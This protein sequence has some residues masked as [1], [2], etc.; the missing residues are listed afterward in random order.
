MKLEF[1]ESGS[2][3]CPLVRLYGFDATEAI[4]L[5]SILQSLSRGTIKSYELHSDPAIQAVD[6]CHLTLKLH[7]CDAGTLLHGNSTF[8][9]MFTAEGWRT[10]EY[11]LAPFC[12]PATAGNGH[13]WLT[14]KETSV[15]SCRPMDGGELPYLLPIG[16]YPVHRRLFVFDLLR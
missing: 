7:T 16:V 2:P 8:E 13:Q 10:V 14:E 15:S 9:C 3:D 5:R 6:R 12:E 11:R 1:L 4:R